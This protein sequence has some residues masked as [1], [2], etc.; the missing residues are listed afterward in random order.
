MR[1]SLLR[2][3][4]AFALFAMMAGASPSV[5]GEPTQAAGAPKAAETSKKP[6]KKKQKPA[7]KPLDGTTLDYAY[8]ARD[9]ARPERAWL[10]R[11]FVHRSAAAS[12]AAPLPLVVFLHGLNTDRIKYRWM[13]G[14]NEGDV[15]RI[16]ADLIE[17]GQIPPAI[18]AAPSSILPAAISNAVTSWPGFDLDRFVD[19]TAERLAGVAAIDRSRIIVAGHSGAGC[20]PKGGL[21]AA[22]KGTTRPLAAISIDTCMMPSVAVELARAHPSTHVI[23]SWQTLSWAKRP[24]TD[25]KATFLRE[26]EKAPPSPDILRELWAA[27][28]T[29]PMPHDAM[30][31][32]T[33]RTWLPKLL[34]PPK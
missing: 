2:S 8:D 1:P 28:P 6:G 29:E 16:V 18:V 5:R 33:F 11:A 24:F 10:G 4:A 23:V 32:L 25:F 27:R 22:L 20:N 30:V 26:V 34:P 3:A 21:A 13:G 9:I 15:R 14:G 31:A 17:T 12:P 7:P 19:L